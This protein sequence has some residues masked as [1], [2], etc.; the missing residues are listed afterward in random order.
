MEKPLKIEE[1]N[2]AIK[3]LPGWEFVN[4]SIRAEFQFN[5]FIEAFSFITAV[6]LESEKMNHHPDWSNSYNKVRIELVTHAAQG[7]TE[8]DILLA[9]KIQHLA[10]MHKG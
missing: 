4:G 3:I 8:K 10:G 1:L 5:T 2:D 6:A 9:R 7:V